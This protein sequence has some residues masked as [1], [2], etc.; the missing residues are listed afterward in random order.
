MAPAE[1]SK[2]AGKKNK[3]IIVA[4]ECN[5]AIPNR[6]KITR[7]SNCEEYNHTLEEL[8]RFKCNSKLRKL[9]G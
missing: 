2:G 8:D 1:Q 3:P 6:V 4:K 7:Y 9:A 5:Y